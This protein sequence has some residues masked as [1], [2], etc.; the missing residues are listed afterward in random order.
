M[1]LLLLVLSEWRVISVAGAPERHDDKVIRDE[2]CGPQ[3]T[4]NRKDFRR[5]S[6]QR[7]HLICALKSHIRKHNCTA[8][9]NHHPVLR[10]SHGLYILQAHGNDTK[11]NRRVKCDTTDKPNIN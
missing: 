3:G 8:R 5:K 2:A 9:S 1:L 4:S 6:R 7:R 11:Q 10:L